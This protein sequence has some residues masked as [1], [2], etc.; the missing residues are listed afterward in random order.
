MILRSNLVCCAL[1]PVF[2]GLA[3]LE[4]DA[5]TNTN[6]PT[7]LSIASQPSGSRPKTRGGLRLELVAGGNLV[8][9]PAAMAFDERGRLFVA[10]LRDYPASPSGQTLSGRVRLL[11]D[12]DGD[13]VFD[14]SVVFADD[15]DRLSGIACSQGGVFVANPEGL[16]FLLDLDGD[17][18]ADVHRRLLNFGMSP[19]PQ[20]P[21]QFP[22]AMTWGPDRRIYV[23]LP[24]SDAEVLNPATPAQPPLNL[25]G[26]GFSF[27]PRTLHLRAEVGQGVVGQAFDE[28]GHRFVTSL[29]ASLTVTVL[30]SADA[31]RNPY[32]PLMPTSVVLVPGTR[33]GGLQDCLIYR[34]HGYPV[35]LQ[36]QAFLADPRAGTVDL[37][38]LVADGIHPT[39][40]TREGAL[41]ISLITGGDSHFRPMQ[42]VTGPD[43]HLYIADLDRAVYPGGEPLATDPDT[44]RADGSGKIWRLVPAAETAA[45]RML[46]DFSNPRSLAAALGNSNAWVRATA[47]RL[48]LERYRT[49][50]ASDLRDVFTRAKWPV[51]RLEA[52]RSLNAAGKATG[53]DLARALGD[54]DVSIRAAAVRMAGGWV[55]NGQM[56]APLWNSLRSRAADGSRGVRLRVAL[57]A[58]SVRR[59]PSSRLI[60]DLYARDSAEVW[61]RRA[62]L[63]VSPETMTPLFLEFLGNPRVRQTAVGRELLLN[64]VTSIGLSGDRQDV[65]DCLRALENLSIPLDLA[66]PVITA[67][68]QG[69]EGAGLRLPQADEE[70]F[71]PGIA[72]TAQNVAVRGEDAQIRSEA[73]KVLGACATSNLVADSYLLLMFAPG[74]PVAMQIPVIDALEQQGLARDFEALSQRWHLW[75]APEQQATLDALLKT[76]AGADALLRSL[77]DK[78]IPLDALTSVHVNLLREYPV[79][80]IRA[81]AERLLGLRQPDRTPLVADFL[82]ALD[83]RGSPARGG[84]LFK[85]RCA[86]CHGSETWTVGPP[87]EEMQSRSAIQLVAGLI[88]PSREITPGFETAMLNLSNGRLAWGV[89]RDVNAQVVQLTTATGSRRYRRDVAGREEQTQWSLMPDNTAAGLTRQDVADLV[90]YIQAGGDKH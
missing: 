81:R 31:Q 62:M 43:D 33:A 76:E 29:S 58:G 77:T 78:T 25:R 72:N 85:A 69:L 64:L 18:I 68:A 86:D 3:L 1:V 38:T 30:D 54:R 20:T 61:M 16:S 10:E 46:P 82:S 11:E 87:V 6:A 5:Q 57:A 88:D 59:P 75:A 44:D 53:G 74:L 60:A 79:N 73:V 83:L 14:S 65:S 34:G 42:L 4:V 41:R 22:R 12:G 45:E 7:A 52:L 21:D 37:V 84:E 50:A 15:L 9:S 32:A 71:W 51:A 8:E 40:V 26:G 48:L 23:A 90:Q 27:D 24:W 56:P 28:A 13:G 67:L 49:N 63:T 2:C 55:R 19:T 39:A 70:G 47:A 89:A 66:F 80:H 17:D 36:G 35:N